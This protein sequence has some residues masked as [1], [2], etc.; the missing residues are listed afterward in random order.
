MTC[1]TE[2]VKSGKTVQYSLTAHAFFFLVEAGGGKCQYPHRKI[3][4]PSF[5]F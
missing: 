4:Y 3:G 5:N 1:A 2:E